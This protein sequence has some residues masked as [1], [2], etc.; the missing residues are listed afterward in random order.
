MEKNLFFKYQLFIIIVAIFFSFYLLGFNYIK[1]TNVD[2]F[3]SK[4]LP[5]YQIGWNYF[6]DDIWRF[7][8]GSNPNFGIY[9]QG[10]IVHNDSIPL[11]AIFFKI[12]N[13]F[14]PSNFQYFSLWILL[15]IYLQLFFSFKIIYKLSNKLVFSLISSLFFCISTILINRVGIHLA[16]FGQWIILSAFYFEINQNKNKLLN[17]NIIT[18]LSI[19][20]NFY[21]T[22]MIVLFYIFQ[23]IYDLFKKKI[24][25]KSIIVES[26]ITLIFVLF[27]MYVVGYF[28]IN[29]DDGFSWGYGFYNFNLNSFFNPLGSNNFEVF[30]WSLFLP[31]QQY[32][33]GEKEGFS[34]LGISGIIFS[35]LFIWNLFYKKYEIFYSNQKLLFIS[36]LFIILAMSHKLNFGKIN[37]LTIPLN[38]YIYLALSTFRASG[39][40]IWPVYYLIFIFG[41]IFI[42][43]SFKNKSPSVIISL[44]LLLQIVDLYPGL[45]KYKLGSQYEYISRDNEIKDDIWN[46]LSN[47]FDQIRL[48]EPQ[49]NSR[50]FHKMSKY[51]QTENFK[52]TDISYLA[53]VNRESIEKEKYS[54]VK[55]F[56]EKNLDIFNKTIF[57]SDNENYV[58]NLRYL[59]GESLSYYYADKLWLISSD[60]IKK[61]NS[62]KKKRIA[63]YNIINLDKKNLINFRNEHLQIA[64]LGWNNSDHESGNIME[65]YLSTILFKIRGKSCQTKSLIKFDIEKF[66]KN[67]LPIE[68]TLIL[69]KNQK[70]EIILNSNRELE[71]EFNCKLNDINTIDINVKNPKSLFD[72][73]RSLSRVKRSI[74]LNSITISN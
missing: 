43:K 55:F 22:I 20:I 68:L 9:Y 3:N 47:S 33:N 7:P 56:N 54:L 39:R 40:L 51:L 49:N 38:D 24:S 64:G 48:L 18:I 71:F 27:S 50:I 70:E 65:G 45:I 31:I 58:R 21:F 36:I 12:F 13:N 46:N 72:L 29:L 52:K 17:R 42:F 66:Y 41:I 59:Y 16:L 10:S 57:V 32:Q 37:I 4:D 74:I 44:L 28:T 6:R 35:F 30:N 26:F 34:Y 19:L 2:W 63:K 14:L 53:R 8:I 25:L 61:K 5:V 73:K 23:D 60:D 62:S 1:P 11:F 15:S 69:N 67:L